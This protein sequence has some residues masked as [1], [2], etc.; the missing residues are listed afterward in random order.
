M[1][2]NLLIV[3]WQY[4]ATRT[5]TANSLGAYSK[6]H[7]SPVPPKD[8]RRCKESTQ[9]QRWR[10]GVSTGQCSPTEQHWSH[11]SAL[12]M[13]TNDPECMP[14]TANMISYVTL[15]LLKIFHW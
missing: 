5:A 2:L 13:H 11:V 10:T 1:M 6:Q 8:S 9:K 15:K 3:V 7:Q 14:D 12:I 4:S